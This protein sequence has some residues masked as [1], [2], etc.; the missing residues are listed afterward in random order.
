VRVQGVVLEDHRDVAVLGLHVGDV[1]V[2]DEHPTGV[3]VFEAGEH[4]QRGR[5]AAAGGADEDEELAI[6]DVEVEP[7]DSGAFGARIG[8][9]RMVESDGCHDEVFPFTGRNV[10]DDPL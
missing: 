2:T 8:P 7:V 5:L 1:A 4:A 3:D 6:A 10:P 9:G